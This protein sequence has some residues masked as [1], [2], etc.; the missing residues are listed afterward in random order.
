MIWQK[1]YSPQYA[2]DLAGGTTVT[3]SPVLAQGGKAP[4]ESLDRAVEIIRDRVNGSGISEAE[5]ARSGDNI[6]ISVPG[7]G[8]AEVVNLVGTTA[9]LRFRQVLAMGPAEQTPVVPTTAPTPGATPTAVPAP[10]ATAGPGSATPSATPSATRPAG[11]AV[12][13]ALAAPT[14]TPSG[15]ATGAT[16]TPAATP[17]GAATPP[18]P[19]QPQDPL[20]GQDLSGIDPAVLADFRKLDCTKKDRGQGTVDDPN[21]QLAACDK[22]GAFKYVLDKAEVLGTDVSGAEAGVDQQTNEWVTTVDFK[23][24]GGIKFGKLTGRVVSLPE[25]RNQV[26]MVL[27]GVVISA[28]RIQEAIPGGQARIS[29]QFTPES[30][31]ELANQ[32]K[33][34]ALPLKFEKSEISTVS[35]TL[36]QDQLHGGLIAGLIGLGLVV[37]YSMFYYRGLGIVSILSLTVAAVLTWE[38]VVL[39]GKLLDFRLSLAGIAGLI[40]AIGITADSFVVF[41]E[42]LRDEAREGKT[43]RAAVER[44]WTRAKRTILVAGAVNFLAAAVLYFLAVGGVKGFAFTLGLTT[45]IDVVVVFL[46][47]KPVVTLLARMKFFNGGHPLSGLDP[48][49]LGIQKS[50]KQ[51]LG[52]AITR[53]A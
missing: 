47:T 31:N 44:G 30:A 39:L 17:T 29:G 12:S 26:A 33:Y 38:L 42:R 15:R 45:L 35:A 2:L 8:Q 27:D 32:L 13:S 49:R 18:P 22:G 19:A 3:L 10:T 6:I 14:P 16:P 51:V 28:P 25:P 9:E 50:P 36:G 53:E 46:F 20:A 11:R 43:L 7:K 37:L 34:G 23:S 1:A 4:D 21:K 40:V 48:D 24:E 5:V 52:R 41:F